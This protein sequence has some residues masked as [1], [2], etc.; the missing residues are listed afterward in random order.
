[1]G[2]PIGIPINLFSYKQCLFRLF[3]DVGEDSTIDIE[4]MTIHGI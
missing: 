3:A 4:H 2:I 1:M